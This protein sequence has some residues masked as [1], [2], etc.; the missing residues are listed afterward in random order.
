VGVYAIAWLRIKFRSGDM[1]QGVCTRI[2]GLVQRVKGCIR[3][4]SEEAPSGREMKTDRRT[5]ADDLKR[6]LIA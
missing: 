3:K 1:L 6:S 4:R 5:D 2:T